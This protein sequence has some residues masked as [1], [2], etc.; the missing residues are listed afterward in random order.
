MFPTPFLE[1]KSK[2]FFEYTPQLHKALVYLKQ[3]G[4]LK[5]SLSFDVSHNDNGRYPRCKTKAYLKV[6]KTD[7][8]TDLY[9]LIRLYFKD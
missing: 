1:T 3:Q 2:A 5:K 4:F 6:Y 7:D 9:D 8:R